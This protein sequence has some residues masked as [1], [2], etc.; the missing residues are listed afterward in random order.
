MAESDSRAPLLS[1]TVLNYNYGHYL[2][3]C[4]DSILS[5]TFRDFEVVVINDKST[6]NSLEVLMPYLADPR[7]RL[8]DHQTN[9][10]FVASL[11]EGAS[12]SRG[13]YISVISA[14]DWVLDSTA[15]AKQIE[16]LERDPEIAFAYTA[17]GHY[18]TPE[19][20]GHV[21]RAAKGNFVRDGR[22]ALQDIV[23]NPYVLHSGTVIR[24]STYEAIGGYDASLKYAV[25][26]KMWFALC[27]A[28]KAAY[29]DEVLYGY[30][31]HPTSMSKSVQSIQR[32][33]EEVLKAIDWSLASSTVE[34][35]KG[36]LGAVH[37]R[38]AKKALI[39]FAADEI[40]RN[41]YREGWRGFWI[42]LKIRPMQT[43]FQRDTSILILRTLLGGG[44]FDTL[45]RVTAKLRLSKGVPVTT[46]AVDR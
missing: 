46:G 2:P 43:L 18:E 39:A 27:H 24:K 41:C 40:F 31:R 4:L 44:G 17:Y 5:Q 6:D 12:L 14:D 20:Q 45:Q 22:E 28:G 23:V 8:V 10:G 7:V 16:V 37:T 34:E 36:A 29:I 21:W 42:A 11:I 26:V 35:Q 3:T 33:I 15:F 30:R 19:R 32:S 13:R 9:K 1:V 25:D 38:A